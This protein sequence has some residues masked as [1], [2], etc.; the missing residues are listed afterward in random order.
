MNKNIYL[1]LIV[2]TVCVLAVAIWNENGPRPEKTGN[3]KLQSAPPPAAQQEKRK[4]D[5]EVPDFTIIDKSPENEKIV[6][7]QYQNTKYKF[8]FSV[9]DGWDY[10][11]PGAAHTI[12]KVGQK[13]MG[14]S[15]IVSVFPYDNPDLKHFQHTQQEMDDLL[16]AGRPAMR[17]LN[18]EPTKVELEKTFLYNHPAY[19][20]WVEYIN[21]GAGIEI[22]YISITTQCVMYGGLYNIII[23]LPKQLW[24]E[25]MANR[26]MNSI[27]SF[28]FDFY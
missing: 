12:V 17:S 8:R 25:E 18:I 20:T 23:M 1:V 19:T 10:Y 5:I 22:E 6:G 27:N 13:R 26:V 16:S 28:R 4:W 21:K 7:S 3:D 15:M 2:V 11:P 9:P 24:T 14:I